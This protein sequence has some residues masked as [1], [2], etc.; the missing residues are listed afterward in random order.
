MFA[1]V[2]GSDGHNGGRQ[3]SGQTS[4]E[5]SG[6]KSLGGGTATG[7]DTTGG[8]AAW[9]HLFGWGGASHKFHSVR[10]G[11]A[12]ERV[13]ERVCLYVCY[14]FILLGNMPEPSL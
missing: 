11:A 12:E 2:C 5:F 4:L 1:C 6:W 9:D 7:P 10:V 14:L 8:F 13:G 3:V